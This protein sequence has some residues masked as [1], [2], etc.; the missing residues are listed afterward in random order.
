MNGADLLDTVD[1]VDALA[2][3]R[4]RW[5][6]PLVVPP[7]GGVPVA[8]TRTTTYVD[9]LEDKWRLQL[10]QQRM[11]ALGLADRPDLVMAVAG[12]RDDAKALNKIT[13]AARE[14]AAA[15][16]AATIG[17]AVHAL[18]E[19]LD[20]GQP[21]GTIPVAYQGDLAAY[22]VATAGLVV[23]EVEQFSVCDA[24][25]IGGTPDRIVDYDGRS[26]VFDIKT[27]SISFG[28]LKIAMQ[29]AVYAHTQPYDPATGMRYP[30]ACPLDQEQAIVAHLPAGQGVC[31]LHF[32]DIA[33]GWRAVQTATA[34]RK[35]RSRKD[36]F[37]PLHPRPHG[38]AGLSAAI[39]AA[40]TVEAL[41][42]LWSA[43][44][45]NGTWTDEHLIAAQA[46]KAQLDYHTGT[47]A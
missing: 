40:P 45:E 6:R 33:A 23:T 3:P 18:C 29:L 19:R 12:A 4:D 42:A 11:V 8:Y 2:I 16:S 46:R 27:G 31:T 32:V 43:A 10:W 13:E 25:R 15:S 5:G 36:W 26:L 47:A 28:A 34:V 38:P 14:A 1:A 37:T 35:W 9:C 17:T 7:G 22:R 41:R 39:A 44:I 20:R 30:R 21:L 24:L